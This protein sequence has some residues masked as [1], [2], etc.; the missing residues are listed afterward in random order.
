M[1][2]GEM[3]G[4]GRCGEWKREGRERVMDKGTMQR[5]SRTS[6]LLLLLLLISSFLLPLLYAL[7]RIPP[8]EV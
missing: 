3:D 8:G 5:D 2:V 7:E 6:L 1:K 4:R